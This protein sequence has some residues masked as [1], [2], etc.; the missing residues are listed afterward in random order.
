MMNARYTLLVGLCLGILCSGCRAQMAPPAQLDLAPEA[1]G[2]LVQRFVATVPW[3]RAPITEV[4]SLQKVLSPNGRLIWVD[5]RATTDTGLC[6]D[7]KP[8]KSIASA[9]RQA[10]AG[11]GVIVRAGVYRESVL[12]ERGGAP[13]RPLTLAAYPGDVVIVSGADPANEGWTASASLW[14]RAWTA[15][16]PM[17]RSKNRPQDAFR[18]ELIVADGL[19]LRAVYTPENLRPG[20]FWVDGEPEAPRRILA[21]FRES[22]SPDSLSIETGMRPMLLAGTDSTVSHI[23]VVGLAFLHAPNSGKNG[24]VQSAGSNWLVEQNL[25]AWCNGLG[26]MVAGLEQTF[27]G[28]WSMYNG[29]MGW[30]SRTSHSL[31][32]DNLSV[33]NNWKGYDARWEA[34]GGKFV[35]TTYTTIRRHYAAYNLGPGIW[36]DINNTH[37]LVEESL[38]VG[39]MKAGIMVE[40][41]ST[42]NVV[43]NNVVYGTRLLDGTGSGIQIQAASNNRIEYNTV[44]SNE[45]DGIRYKHGDGRAASG[46]TVF[47]RNLLINNGIGPTRAQEIRVEGTPPLDNPDT[48]AENV[49]GRRGNE[50][51]IFFVAEMPSNDLDTWQRFSQATD[52]R[53]QP[54]PRRVLTDVQN[55]EGW[56]VT[57]EF[58]LAAF[59]VQAAEVGP[60]Q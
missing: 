23:R 12:F 57:A 43:R 24:C 60:A 5:Q 44:Y 8:C 18:P 13:D 58:D 20:A 17:H 59:G 25:V 37:N 16:L 46:G 19:P 49:Y 27:R 30:G 36:L 11:D 15:S 38:V 50:D 54:H 28:N 39:N 1:A 56:R 48:F 35:E 42:D 10:K 6:T 2:P 31:L 52:D 9:L 45:G 32:E 33:G 7:Q 47:Y 3:H 41:Q 55:Q 4:D 21:R 29:Q 40:Y 51:A 22:R 26:I 34:G 53:I 14:E